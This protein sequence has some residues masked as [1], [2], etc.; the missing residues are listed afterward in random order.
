MN[1]LAYL[2]V[3]MFLDAGPC[4]PEPHESD[5]RAF[6]TAAEARE[7]I[8]FANGQLEHL[9]T[10]SGANSRSSAAAEMAIE[11]VEFAIYLWRIVRDARKCQDD[12]WTEEP[13]GD[14]R[15]CWGVLDGLQR[16]R[17]CLTADEYRA[18]RLPR[19]VFYLVNP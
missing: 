1:T 8:E 15:E 6:P 11:R 16:I 17:E 2:V 9:K 3:C 5:L 14:Y 12:D 7:Y 13:C 18:G 4:E 19:P 10:I